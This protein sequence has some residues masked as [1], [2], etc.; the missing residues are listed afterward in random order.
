ML[1]TFYLC[2]FPNEFGSLRSQIARNVCV[3]A[4]QTPCIRVARRNALQT[5]TER[6][7]RGASETFSTPQPKPK[8][9]GRMR[10]RR[11][12]NVRCGCCWRSASAGTR[13]SP[14]ASPPRSA[15]P[16]R[17]F[18]RQCSGASTCRPVANGSGSFGPAVRHGPVGRA[19]PPGS[20]GFRVCGV[21]RVM[22][23][24]RNLNTNACA[25][26]GSGACPGPG[27]V[28]GALCRRPGQI[29]ARHDGPGR[30]PVARQGHGGHRQS[31][32]GRWVVW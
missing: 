20:V 31:G 2:L 29:P 4:R 22:R 3:F 19:R 21:C 8:P 25:C 9:N 26:A 32:A 16:T 23:I 18:L 12:P 11:P 14:S 7:C 13:T 24:D 27:P 6:G 5:A 10:L 15:P 17:A 30:I 1:R 28:R